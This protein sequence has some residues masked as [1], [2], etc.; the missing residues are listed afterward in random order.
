MSNTRTSRPRPTT[1]KKDS[2]KPN[3][4]NLDTLQREGEPPEPYICILKG[5]LY[6]F[7]DPADMEWQDAARMGADDI[8]AFIRGLL[9]EK[10]WD[11]F[12]EVRL[13]LWKVSEL[14]KDIQKHYG[15]TAENEG[16]DSEPAGS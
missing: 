7:T 12:K 13:E 9:Q 1:A 14:A 10:D 8:L 6:T 4:L 3:G 16:K 2:L 15:I 5:R 11:E